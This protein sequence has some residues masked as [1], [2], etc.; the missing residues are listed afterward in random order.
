ML[1]ISWRSG[2]RAEG[3]VR[4]RVWPQAGETVKT[5]R[6]ATDRS[7]RCMAAVTPSDLK[8]GR[9]CWQMTRSLQ[10]QDITP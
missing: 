6:P 9:L 1:E 3:P 10:S 2:T 8:R 7:A 4:G 5:A